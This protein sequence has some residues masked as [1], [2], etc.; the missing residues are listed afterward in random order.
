[1]PR[2]GAR[3]SPTGR[4]NGPPMTLGNM[5][6][7]GVGTLDVWC[8]GRDCHHHRMLDVDAMPDDVAVPSIGPAT[9]MRALRPPRR[10]RTAELVGIPGAGRLAARGV[11]MR[12]YWLVY[13]KDDLTI[14]QVVQAYSLVAAR[15]R[16]DIATPRLGVH[17]VEG[18]ELD[19]TTAARVPKNMIDRMLNK[20]EAERLL[21]RIAREQPRK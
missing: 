21:G 19:E 5:R 14:V 13:R 6:Q 11:L 8:L 20:A 9:A 2:D 12:L 4:Y 18:H 15:L 3:T 17:F 7:N 16:A 1:M 10:R